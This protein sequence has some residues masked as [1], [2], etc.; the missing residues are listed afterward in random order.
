MLTSVRIILNDVIGGYD[1]AGAGRSYERQEGVQHIL[2]VIISGLCDIAL[3]GRF[4]STVL[5]QFNSPLDLAENSDNT[6]LRL[7][8]FTNLLIGQTS[9]SPMV[10]VT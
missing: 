6:F 4:W 7:A 8:V 9:I 3:F 2:L 10:Q 1:V 5:I